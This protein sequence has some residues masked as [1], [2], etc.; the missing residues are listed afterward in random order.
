MRESS[1]NVIVLVDDDNVLEPDYLSAALRVGRE[2]SR[3]GTWGSGS[4]LPEYEL[5]PP[6]ALKDFLPYLALTEA[7]VPRRGMFRLTKQIQGLDSQKYLANLHAIA[8]ARHVID[9]ERM[10]A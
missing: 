8:E 7:D 1:A 6:E 5:R 2:W 3:L 10:E 4:T 9:A